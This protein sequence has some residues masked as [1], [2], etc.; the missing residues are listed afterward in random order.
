MN[1]VLPHFSC[2]DVT[3]QAIKACKGSGGTAPYNRKLNSRGKKAFA[4]VLEK[5]PQVHSEG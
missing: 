3:V 4:L 5:K 2:R 1:F